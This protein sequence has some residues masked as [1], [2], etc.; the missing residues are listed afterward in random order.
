M[1]EKNTGVFS[2]ALIWG[3][4]LGLV[5]IIYAVVLY[6]MDESLNKTL[7]YFGSI[8]TIAVLVY[9]T[10]NF[11]DSVRGGILPFGSAFSFGVVVVVIGAVI[12][13]I[14][15][16][17]QFAIIDTGLQDKMLEMAM[18][19]MIEKGVPEDQLDTAMRMTSKF[20]RPVMLSIFGLFGGSV[21]GVILALIN[22]AIFKKEEPLGPPEEIIEAE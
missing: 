21:I 2:N 11:R 7:G 19:Q 3:V 18:E 15:T 14:Y 9:G 1:E 16:Y 13:S 5:S 22:A 4:I 20:M 8:V 17:I 10:I 6:V 12:S